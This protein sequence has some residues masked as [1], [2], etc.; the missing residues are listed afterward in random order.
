MTTVETAAGHRMSGHDAS[1][2]D[3][4]T[5]ARDASAPASE[6]APGLVV[7]QFRQI[8]TWPLQLMPLKEGAQIQNHWELLTEIDDPLVGRPWAELK[9]EFPVDPAGFQERHYREFVGFLPRAQRFLYGERASRSGRTSYGDSPIRIYR[10]DDIRRVR[11]WLRRGTAPI[12]LAVAHA[13]L[14][15]FY[16]VDVVV[17]VFELGGEDLPL[18]VAQEFVYRFARAY[19]SGWSDT[20]EAENCPARVEWLAA[21]G[22]VLAVSDYDDRPK[23]TASVCRN[24]APTVAAHWDFLLRPLRINHADPPGPLRYRPLEYY[25][26]PSMVYLAV[27]DPGRMSQSDLVRLTLGVLPD[28]RPGLPYAARFLADFDQKYAYD[29]YHDPGRGGDWCDTRITC[30]GHT[31]VVV[32]DARHPVFTDA[33]RGFLAQFRHQIFMLGLVA[34]FHRAALLMLSERLMSMITRLDIDDP[35]TVR[36]FRRDIRQTQEIFLRFTHRYWF[37]ELSDQAMA[38]D[39]F[40]RWADHLA[41]ERLYADVRAQISDMSTYLDSDMLRRQ[42]TTIVRLTVV[43]M[44][45]ILGTVTTGFLGM[46]LF[47]HAEEPSLT[48]LAIFSTVLA[49][50]TL[51]TYLVLRR[52][53]ALARFFESVADTRTTLGDQGRTLRDVF[54]RGGD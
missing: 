12:E 5:T 38:R 34:H 2:H 29:R 51:M 44:M 40:H 14:Y 46:N 53:Q 13:D 33:E 52:S 42:S 35:A 23:F 50:I 43:T 15:F 28:R 27:D 54:R 30:T 10:R 41:L 36:S 22:A 4:A 16:D 24:I 11:T 18:A 3:A 25:R 26:M 19:P 9:D 31:F 7:R 6:A 20:G 49:G 21:D 17:L 45:S 32:G 37:S 48:K 1:S 8:V 47:A 39:L